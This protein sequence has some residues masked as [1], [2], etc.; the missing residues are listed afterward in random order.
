LNKRLE[1]TGVLQEKRK[2][3]FL[4]GKESPD[5]LIKVFLRGKKRQAITIQHIALRYVVRR[6]YKTSEL[7]CF[8]RPDISEWDHSINLL[9]ILA[10]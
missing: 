7:V 6:S 10:F 8:Y 4:A 1:R 5:L 9:Q 2:A 3:G